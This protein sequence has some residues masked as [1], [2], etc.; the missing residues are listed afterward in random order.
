MKK[1][2]MMTDD[3]YYTDYLVGLKQDYGDK[4]YQLIADQRIRSQR[5][6]TNQFY[7]GTYPPNNDSQV[8]YYFTPSVVNTLSMNLVNI[9]ST[10]RD[11]VK[12][13]PRSN[14][15]QVVAAA[16]QL[17]EMANIVFHRDN[18]GFELME[19]NFNSAGVDKNAWTQVYWEDNIESYEEDYENITEA[20]LAQVIQQKEQQG[21][22]C[23]VTYDSETEA[24]GLEPAIDPN[25]GVPARDLFGELVTN[26]IPALHNY[27]LKCEY[28]K[29]C[30]K[31]DCIAPEDISFNDGAVSLD[32]NDKTFNYIVRRTDVLI[33][34]AKMMFPDIDEE[35]FG[36]AGQSYYHYEK[37][38]RHSF[39]GTYEEYDGIESNPDD[40][41]VELHE[42]LVR[43]DRDDDGIAEWRYA[44]VSGTTLC[45]DEP[46][47]GGNCFSTFT[48]FPIEHKVWGMSVN[49]KCL[50]WEILATGTVRAF[51]KSNRLRNTVR[52][53]V[54]GE[55]DNQTLNSGQEGFIPMDGN[56]DAQDIFLIPAPQPDTSALQVLQML[57]TQ[58]KAEFGVDRVV[59]QISADIEKS[60]ND[61]QKTAMATENA[62]IKM[63]GH[64]RRY[65][66]SMLR[67]NIWL[68]AME[69]VK[70][71]DDPYVIELAESVAPGQGFLAG[72]MGIHS[73]LN[74]TDLQAKV[75]LGHQS[76]S[77]KITALAT[78]NQTINALEQNPSPAVYNLLKDALEGFGFD[79]PDE[80]L[81]GWDYYQQR[82]QMLDQQQQAVVQQAQ[83]AQMQAQTQAQVAQQTVALKQQEQQT[84][85]Q[86]K[87]ME[88]ETKNALNA[89][90]ALEAESKAAL[91]K[92]ETIIAQSTAENP[93]E[94]NVRV[95]I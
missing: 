1:D 48:Y 69:L 43:V 51:S 15:P 77:Q 40:P 92:V 62:S 31:I 89:A 74:K 84:A 46:Y 32:F 28:K 4:N 94:T 47:Y 18:N 19:N 55:L 41:M 9:F 37:A 82:R 68:I 56:T 17:S 73:I 63:F 49:D 58:V 85:A 13:S 83:A 7:D 90:K 88:T 44:V 20:E 12:F 71:K 8:K 22:T 70:H 78:L 3:Q 14:N 21:Y 59:G 80:T 2:N 26:E 35:D 91:T 24:S 27:T 75:G 30:I 16:D 33:S 45:K 66:E 50:D 60:G 39:D 57:E 11:T 53:F 86:L 95:N 29:G 64:A 6:Y 34:D 5:A 61:A 72:Q 87:L 76:N 42:I 67:N 25:T 79:N 10:N 23:E 54:S 81:G 52:G 36:K 38:A 65:V 93:D